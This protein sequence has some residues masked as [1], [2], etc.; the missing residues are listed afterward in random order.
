M[1]KTRQDLLAIFQ[2]GLDAVAGKAVVSEEIKKISYP[3]N[4]HVIAIGKASDAMLQGIPKER[5]ISALLISK[6]GHISTKSNSA[7]HIQCLESDHPIPKESSLKAGQ[8]LINYLKELP[9]NEPCVFLI[10]GGTSAL[11]EVLED[12]WSLL[13][14]SELTNYLLANA[15]PI[16]QINAVRKQLS[17]IKGGSL[18]NYMGDRPVS[19]LMISDVPND[20]PTDIGSGLLFS[21]INNSSSLLSDVADLSKI[22]AKWVNKLS[23]EKNHVTPADFQW[24]IIASLSKAK[25]ACALQAKDLGYE[26][27]EVPDFLEG[28]ASEAAKNCVL[29]M[30]K[31]PNTLFIWGGETTVHLPKKPGKGGR[32]QHLA[33]AG[34]IAMDNKEGMCLL[35]AGTDG[36]DGMTTATGALVDGDTVEEGEQLGLNAKNYLAQADSNTFFTQTNE[37]IITGATGTNVMDL[38]LG[39]YSPKKI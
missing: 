37:L 32:N 30:R 9:D 27:K 4:F 5:T 18:W 20:K 16:D 17:K 33:L 36:T 31:E 8:A 22:P 7:T 25:Q 24:K 15:Y 6:H 12:D 35:V 28:E 2:A 39:I 34:A 14:L 11:V 1:N 19:C 13:E 23:P 21:E 29:Q 3:K 26:V 38:V 10:S